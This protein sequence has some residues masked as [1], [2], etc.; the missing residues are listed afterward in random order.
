M[1][2]SVAE[3]FDQYLLSAY[4]TRSLP[5]TQLQ[6][7]RRAFYAGA[8]GLFCESGLSRD[9]QRVYQDELDAYKQDALA[10]RK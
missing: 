9:E 2:Q 7:V 1:R 3:M 6:E 8:H 4:G 5:H 10:G